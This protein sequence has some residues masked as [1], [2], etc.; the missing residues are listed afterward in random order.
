MSL[1]GFPLLPASGGF[2]GMTKLLQAAVNET[3]RDKV[4]HCTS[5]KG[6]DLFYRKIVV[7]KTEQAFFVK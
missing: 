1:P 3:L 4:P 2:A 5:S 6:T 7:I